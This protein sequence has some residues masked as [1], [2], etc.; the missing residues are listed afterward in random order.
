M[1]CSSKTGVRA[2]IVSS[3][4]GTSVFYQK[5]SIAAMPDRG[6]KRKTIAG[7]DDRG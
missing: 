3:K 7:G 2:P 4:R 6:Y 1:T 5:F